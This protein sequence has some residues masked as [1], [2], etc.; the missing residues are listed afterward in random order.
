MISTNYL[1]EDKEYAYITPQ[2]SFYLPINREIILM[3]YLW[4]P[5]Q[6][7]IL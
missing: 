5:I 2:L 6:L 7:Y 1:L 3:F 4:L